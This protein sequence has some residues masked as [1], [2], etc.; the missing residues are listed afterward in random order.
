MTDFTAISFSADGT[1]QAMTREDLFP[2]GFLG[3]QRIT[4]ASELKFNEHTQD[5]GIHLATDVEGEFA[6]PVDGATGFPTYE[7]ARKA[8]V[9]WL[10]HSRLLNI[11]P[12]SERGVQIL[13]MVRG[14][15]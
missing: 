3:K 10:E 12:T 8:E 13:K 14:H 11:S 15:D 6:D 2:L 7:A 9:S 1:V 4:R 5:W